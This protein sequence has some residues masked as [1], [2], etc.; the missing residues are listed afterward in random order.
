MSYIFK[1]RKQVQRGYVSA[2]GPTAGA[3]VWGQACQILQPPSSRL[4]PDP[5]HTVKTQGLLGTKTP[6]AA[7]GF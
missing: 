4:Y 6:K 1:V 7:Y 3:G 2:L 5:H